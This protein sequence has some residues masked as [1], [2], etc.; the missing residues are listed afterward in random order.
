MYHLL[1]KG[2]AWNI[3]EGPRRRVGPS[4]TSVP[5]ALRAMWFW[6]WLDIRERFI[7]GCIWFTFD[8]FWSRPSMALSLQSMQVSGNDYHLSLFVLPL[9]IVPSYM[10]IHS[11]WLRSL[12]SFEH[13]ANFEV[14]IS[15]VNAQFLCNASSGWLAWCFVGWPVTFCRQLGWRPWHLTTIGFTAWSP[16]AL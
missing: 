8:I 12:C 15:K 3:P 5:W 1:I 10:L 11:S 2:I 9:D 4:S 6:L 7:V 14:K 13:F 16:R